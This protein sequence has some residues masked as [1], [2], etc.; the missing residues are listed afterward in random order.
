MSTKNVMMQ[1]M[2]TS[3]SREP[4]RAYKLQR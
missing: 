3:T 1:L 4:R 2:R